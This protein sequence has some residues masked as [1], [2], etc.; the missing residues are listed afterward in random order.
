MATFLREEIQDGLRR[1]GELAQAQGFHVRLALVGG[2][3]KWYWDM[4]PDNP[5]VMWML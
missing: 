2:A 1:L 4:M 3:A 5:R